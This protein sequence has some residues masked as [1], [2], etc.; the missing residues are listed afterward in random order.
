MWF[1]VA[2]RVGCSVAKAKSS[3]PV[4][5]F[6]RWVKRRE[7]EESYEG[8]NRHR[9][10]D[11]WFAKI[12]LY[13]DRLTFVQTAKKGDKFSK[14]EEDYLLEFKKKE[15]TLGLEPDEGTKRRWKNQDRM[16]LAMLK[17]TKKGEKPKGKLV[18]QKPP[19]RPAPTRGKD[20]GHRKDRS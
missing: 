17:P 6:L 20:R 16:I 8:W 5:E 7:D 11:Y 19:R 14:T 1:W 12:L 2:E 10:E 15:K 4:P 3:I 18:T 9:R 13:I